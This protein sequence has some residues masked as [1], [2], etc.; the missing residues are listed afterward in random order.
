MRAIAAIDPAN[1]LPIPYLIGYLKD[2][3]VKEQLKTCPAIALAG[4][5]LWVCGSLDD[6][7]VGSLQEA[8]DRFRM[9]RTSPLRSWAATLLGRMEMR[10]A[11]AALAALSEACEDSDPE[12]R[13]AA[14]KA[15]QQLHAQ[16]R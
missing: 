2:R 11:N 3:Q 1:S 12:I 7:A 13:S 15:I 5:K 14:A 8:L 10:V 4:F 16:R 6:E 9:E